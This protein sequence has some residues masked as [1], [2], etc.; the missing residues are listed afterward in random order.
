MD[1]I[2]LKVKLSAYAKGTIP[3]KVSD[4]DNDLD[5]IPDAPNDGNSYLRRDKE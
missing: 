5:F 1:N 2:K 3:I 4:L